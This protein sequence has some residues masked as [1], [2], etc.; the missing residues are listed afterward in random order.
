MHEKANAAIK[1]AQVYVELGANP[2]ADEDEVEAARDVFQTLIA[3]AV[4]PTI[5]QQVVKQPP[6]IQTS[7]VAIHLNAMLEEYDRQIIVS[8][9]QLRNYVTNKLVFESNNPDAK[10]RMKALELLGKIG[11]VGLFVERT[12]VTVHQK[13]TIELEE[14]VRSKLARLLGESDVS[15]AKIVENKP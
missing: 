6:Q 8:A 15:D 14:K 12:E 1:A 13:T 11:D 7:A 2:L 5:T 9:Q 4:D 3:P 10:I